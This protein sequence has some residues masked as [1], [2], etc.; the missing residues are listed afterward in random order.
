LEQDDRPSPIKV[1]PREIERMT[2]QEAKEILRDA[3][4]PRDA[5]DLTARLLASPGRLNLI[6]TSTAGELPEVIHTA[7]R[8]FALCW[9]CDVTLLGSL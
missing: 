2:Y 7:T 5:R 3:V 6:D 8:F 4:A 9:W 1:S